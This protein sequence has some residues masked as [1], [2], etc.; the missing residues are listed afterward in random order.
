M[1]DPPVP[2]GSDTARAQIVRFV[3][4]LPTGATET[5][6]F[7]H[8]ARRFAV[9]EPTTVE[10][11]LQKPR[12]AEPPVDLLRLL[13][14]PSGAASPFEFQR[15]AEAWIR[16]TGPA[17]GEPIVDLQLRSERILW[18]PG[19]AVV[20]GGVERFDEILPGLI[21]FAFYEGELR[22]LEHEIDADWPAAEA[23]IP[24]THSVDRGA[25]V[26][27]EHVDTMTR[28]AALR[29]IR[30]A[31]LAPCLQKPSPALSGSARRLAG[32][33]AAQAEVAERLGHVDDRLEVFEDLYELA[34]DRL[35]EFSYFSREFS[36]ELWIVL[37]LLAELI[38]MIADLWVSSRSM[39]R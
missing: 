23:D 1:N 38:V 13:L 35:S 10:A 12:A 37:L 36:L 11:L 20:I 7:W 29:R 39:G 26:R 2:P 5:E 28:Q 22:K 16:E 18:R 31:R 8:P 19:D 21:Q 3:A 24:L 30:F 17:I 9:A 27:R 34:N 33:L 4:E 32:E 15:Q 6:A 25:L 14:V